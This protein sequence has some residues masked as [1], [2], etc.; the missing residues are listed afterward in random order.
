MSDQQP[1]WPEVTPFM[2]CDLVD[3]GDRIGKLAEEL[4]MPPS[5]VDE[6]LRVVYREYARGYDAAW[7][8]AGL[9]NYCFQPHSDCECEEDDDE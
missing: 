1:A 5:L 6:L 8:S 9:C 2:L 7:E 4:K 3:S